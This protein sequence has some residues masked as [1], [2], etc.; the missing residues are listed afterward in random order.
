MCACMRSAV[1]LYGVIMDTDYSE[2][3][4]DLGYT[5]KDKSLLEQAFTHTT[6]VFEHGGQH[7][8]SNQRLEFIG[9]AVLD[10]VVGRRL[11][12]LNATADEGYLSKMR[13]IAVCERSFADC[14]RTLKMGDYLKLGKGEAQSGGSDKDSTLAD[15]FESVI[16]AVYFDGGFECVR[17]CILNILSDTIDR[18]VKGEIFL[19]YKSRLL[20]LAQM[21]GKQHTIRFTVADQRGPA[22]MREFDVEVYADDVLLAR[23]TGHSKKDAEQKCAQKGIEAYQEKFPLSSGRL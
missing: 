21:R 17:D 13:S 16:A 10:L 2:F 19:D 22:H 12:E 3:E 11:Y 15:C 5:F 7:C 6:Y 8:E 20:E 18:A 4:R 23:A 1:I 9:D 14:A